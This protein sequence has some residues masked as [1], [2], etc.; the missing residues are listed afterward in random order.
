MVNDRVG[1]LNAKLIPFGIK[2]REPHSSFSSSCPC[3]S[4]SFLFRDASLNRYRDRDTVRGKGGKE[5]EI[6][7]EIEKINR[8]KIEIDHREEE[9]QKKMETLG[10]KTLFVGALG[11]CSM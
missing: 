5:K 9:R 11:L 3:S 10:R 6:E 4:S 2:L 7:E 8:E 1:I